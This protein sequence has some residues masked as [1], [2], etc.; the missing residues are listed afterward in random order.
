[1]TDHVVHIHHYLSFSVIHRT[2]QKSA[3]Q[4][5]LPASLNIQ[6]LIRVLQ[7]HVSQF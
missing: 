7:V 4:I 2:K 6:C 1:M 3:K 5:P